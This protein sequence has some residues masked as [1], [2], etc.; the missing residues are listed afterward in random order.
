M[1]KDLSFSGGCLAATLGRK[2]KGT[3]ALFI[4]RRRPLKVGTAENWKIS[5]AAVVAPLIDSSFRKD[6][7]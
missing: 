4:Y 7:Q 5:K 3:A 1:N 6:G 2:N